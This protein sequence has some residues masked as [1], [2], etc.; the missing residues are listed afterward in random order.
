MGEGRGEMEKSPCN[1]AIFDYSFYLGIEFWE[2]L[3]KPYDKNPFSYLNLIFFL[4][5]NESPD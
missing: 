4:A 5:Y 2:A 3:Q 1:F